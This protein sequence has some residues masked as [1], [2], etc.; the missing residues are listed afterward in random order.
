MSITEQRDVTVNGVPY[1]VVAWECSDP[2]V[3][4]I[5]AYE[6]TNSY[7]S[8]ATS[9]DDLGHGA[10]WGAVRHRHGDGSRE[11]KRSRVELSLR[12]IAAA[13]PEYVDRWFVVENGSDKLGFVE[14]EQPPV[15][16]RKAFK[17][18]GVSLDDPAGLPTDFAKFLAA[19]GVVSES[20]AQR[21]W[22]ERML[23]S[24]GVL[25]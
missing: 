23:C 13:F 5:D 16:V 21:Q 6:S 10:V 18:L 25:P 14:V 20:P 17:A 15:E 9:R 7:W 4:R 2:W 22:S 8:H 12:V 24:I 1:R 3:T 11:W 19:M